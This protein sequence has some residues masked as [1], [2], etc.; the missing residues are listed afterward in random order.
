[1]DG[2]I[3]LIHSAQ[4]IF[5]EVP[6]YKIGMTEQKTY[7][8]FNQYPYGSK[9]LFHIACVNYRVAERQL[10]DIFR[11]KY[12]Q[13]DDGLEY[14]E[15]D[16]DDMIEDI[17]NFIKNHNKVVEVPEVEYDKKTSPSLLWDL[18]YIV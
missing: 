14:F 11:A 4:H 7:G 17:Y 16:K 18:N 12:R 2:A 15:G 9:L 1:M 8:R 10:L 3:Y 13:T 6:V 5:Q